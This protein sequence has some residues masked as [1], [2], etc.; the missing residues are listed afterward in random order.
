MTV[1][2]AFRCLYAFDAV[3]LVTTEVLRD[4]DI[5]LVKEGCRL[6]PPYGVLIVRTGMDLFLDKEFGLEAKSTDI[7][8]A[9][10]QQGQ[11]I[12]ESMRNQLLRGGVQCSP[13]ANSVYL[14]S[15]PGMLAARAVNF[16]G[17]K[18]IW[19]EYDFMKGILD[20]IGKRRY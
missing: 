13:Q 12:R 14:C 4:S 3:V 5:A 1:I 16:D 15:G 10:V 11:I 6:F 19:D 9:Q 7:K 20:C 18:Y 17:T 8:D 2:C